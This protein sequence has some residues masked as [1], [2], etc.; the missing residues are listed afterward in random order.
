MLIR[1]FL[2][3]MALMFAAFGLWSL[4]SPLEM[5]SGL[6]MQVSG[7]NGAY[8][9]R[10]IY[11]GV[12]LAAAGLCGAGA[13]RTAL[14]QPAL[15]FLVVYMGGYSFARAAALL[16]G[17]PPAPAFATFVAFEVISFVLAAAALRATHK[18]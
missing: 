13:A 5:A 12:S 7:P 11:G 18:A 9:L 1:I 17:P 4:V 10:G 3:L 15:W 6:G 14:R 8:E 16:L 2:A